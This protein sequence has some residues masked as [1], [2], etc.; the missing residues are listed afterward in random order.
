MAISTELV[1]KV[2]GHYRILQ[3][4]GG[5][6]MGVVYEA[7]DLRLGR[8]VALKFL[9]EELAKDPH[10]LERFQEEARAASALAHPNICTFYDFG[11]HAGQPFIAMQYLE[12]GTLKQKVAGKP[13]DLE[14]VLDLGI[15]IA[16]ALDTA[17]AKGIIHRDIKP[18][19]IFVTTRGQA[20]ILD[21]G[22]AKLVPT[23]WPVAGEVSAGATAAATWIGESNLTGPGS[24]LG[25]IAYMS[26]EQARGQELDARS[27]LF[28]FG[29]VLYEMATGH[30]AF[31]GNTTASLFDAL[32]HEA[33]TSPVRLNPE[34]PAELE[35]IVSKALEKDRELRYQVASEMRADLRRL[36]RDTE[37]VR[38]VTAGAPT[39]NRAAVPQATGTLPA[40]P[41]QKL[42]WVEVLAGAVGA[43]LLL[44]VV[45]WYFWG[46]M[47]WRRPELK[48]L[49]LTSNSLESPATTAAAIS[50]DGKYIA[51]ANETGINLRLIGT[52][53][54]HVLSTSAGSR[55]SRLSWFS[56]GTTLLESGEDAKDNVSSIWS[57]SILGGAPR[58][59]R[60]DA[61]GASASPDGSRIAFTSGNGEEIWLMGA[62]GEEPQPIVAG[63]EGDSFQW[64]LWFADGQRVA[65]ARGHSVAGELAFTIESHGVKTGQATTIFSDPR[66]TS[67]CLLT[68]GRMI[69]SVSEPRPKQ[70]DANLWEIRIDARTGQAASHPRRITNWAGFTLSD[71][72][73]AADGRR[74]AFLKGSSQADVYVGEL[75]KNGARLKMPR[76]LTPDDRNDFPTA[77][78]PDSRAVLFFS[79]RN[80]KWDIF[81]Q[82]LDKRTADSI[83]EGTQNYVLP[84]VSADGASIFYHASLKSELFSWSEPAN[85]MRVPI[86][87]GPPQLVRYEPS[88]L[89]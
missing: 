73:V 35:R 68:D 89:R 10:A 46:P 13:L 1:G 33:P 29:A 34:L 37:N 58:R 40:V 62:N 65:Y 67:G 30:Q 79:D 27:D 42:R 57:I 24:A 64:P 25:T 45:G 66:F 63:A 14:T 83:V 36:K 17:H 84:R 82:A 7:E 22:L 60:E 16:D 72:S 31:V 51:Y 49:Q 32:L 48:Q 70:N 59:L 39:V 71:L 76:R 74:L 88:Q 50:P 18:A 61:G 54:T 86:S 15:Q 80:G 11:E 28:A 69:Y 5:G 23:G 19:N 38:A 26:P 4:L 75:E 52:G 44:A 85:L 8:H 47:E 9:P 3:M 77:W 56:E 55:I 21:F 87:G 6:G 78:T 20:K 12:G 43:V 2:L 81:K 41:V 53:K